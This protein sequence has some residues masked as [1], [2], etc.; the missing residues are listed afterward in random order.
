MV[1]CESVGAGNLQVLSRNYS[2]MSL[3][4]DHNVNSWYVTYVQSGAFKEEGA[5]MLRIP[6]GNIEE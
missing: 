6:N 1:A 5:Y 4:A 2:P 3:H